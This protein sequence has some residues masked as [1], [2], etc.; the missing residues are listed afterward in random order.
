MVFVEWW[1]YPVLLTVGIAAGLV[2]SV[3]GGGGLIALPVLL[4]LGFPPPLALGT[5]KLQASFGSSSAAWHYGQSGLFDLRSYAVGIAAT[6]MG[7]IVGAVAVQQLDP[8]V[9]QVFVPWSL[10][11]VVV[12][13]ALRPNAGQGDHPPRVNQTV[14]FVIVGLVLGFYDG[15]LGPGTGSFWT[16]L[17]I[18]LLG[19]NFL[20][21]TAVTK[22]MNATSNLASLV[23]FLHH[24]SV[25]F[26]AGLVMGTG[27][28]IGAR[29]GTRVAIA[30]GA[31]FIRPVFLVM[32]V[33]LV[34]RLLFVQFFH[35]KS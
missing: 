27:Q 28:L 26:V 9:L 17:M 29:L 33:L 25:E 5:N 12:Y 30:H 18:A 24:G 6:L 20:K 11:A 31:R 1:T 8:R 35:A 7:A 16:M 34:A 21:A 23:I 14:F 15:F 13:F 22:V 4:S 2:D 3:A 19:F 10:A 32:V